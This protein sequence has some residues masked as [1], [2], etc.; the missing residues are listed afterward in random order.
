VEQL[1]T[2]LGGI[3]RTAAICKKPDQAAFAELLS[4][5]QSDIE[6]ITVIKDSNRKDRVWFNHLSLVAEGSPAVAWI[7]VV[8]LSFWCSVP[9][10]SRP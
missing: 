3:I 1:Y 2:H 7:T 9:V 5:L 4:D 6:A 8:L 10:V